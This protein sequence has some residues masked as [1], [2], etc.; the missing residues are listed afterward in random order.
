MDI[1]DRRVAAVGELS[2]D[3]RFV[4]WPKVR[5]F[6]GGLQP[7]LLIHCRGKRLRNRALD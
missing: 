7:V 2:P 6:C 1:F 4:P 3:Q 5:Y